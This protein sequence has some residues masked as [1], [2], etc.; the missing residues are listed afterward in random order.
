MVKDPSSAVVRGATV[1]VY[2]VETGVMERRVTTNADGLYTAGL[3]R[4]GSYRVE[5][6]DQSF[7]K[8]VATLAVRLN[9]LERHDLPVT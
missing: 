7:G 8:Y 9:E 4:P 5:V 1:E 2:N 6:T 3:L